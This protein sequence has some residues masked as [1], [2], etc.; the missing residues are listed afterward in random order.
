M[1]DKDAWGSDPSVQVMRK[2]FQAMEQAQHAFLKQLA[3]APDDQRL[4]QWREQALVLFEKA[5][6]VAKQLGIAMDEET[7]AA[8]YCSLLARIM[9]SAGIV[10][11]AVLLPAGEDVRDIIKAVCT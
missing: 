9:G 11:P 3:I 4:R 2:V 1:A 7:A 8:V 6:V 10:I 5:W